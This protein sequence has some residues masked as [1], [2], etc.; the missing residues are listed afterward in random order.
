MKAIMVMY[1][2]LRRD[3][4]APYGC[5]WTH[6]PNFRR[7]AERAASFRN[8]YVGSMPCMPAR[9]ELHTGRYNL[10]HR[11]W[12]PLEPF[13]DSMPELLKNAG[14]Y[15]HLISDHYHYWEDGGGTF[16]NRY[17]SWEAVRGQE[18][19]NWKADLS[20][21]P[22]PTAQG[23]EQ[24]ADKRVYQK[25]IH[26]AVNRARMDSEEKMPQTKTFA[27]ALE[28]LETNHGADNWFLQ[29]ETFDPH[30]PFFTQPERR[31]LYPDSYVGD[32]AD[33]PPYRP[34]SEE[35]E[36]V[37]HIRNDYAAL[38]TMCD[39]YLGRIL[40]AMDTYDLWRDTM[41]IVNTDH[42]F[43][44]SEHGWWGKKGMPLYNEIAHV[45]LF[46]YDPRV[47]AAAGKTCDHL[48]QTVDLPA[49]LL[50]FFGQPLP[51]DMQGRPIGPALTGGGTV[52]D[53]ALYGF[54]GG[55]LNI[56]DGKH[57]YMRAPRDPGCPLYEY[58]LMPTHIHHRFRVEELQDI[59]LAEPFSFTKGCRLMQIAGRAWGDDID[60]G[61]LLFDAG[62]DEGQQAPL[63]DAAVTRQM[64]ALMERAMGENDAPAEQLARMGFLPR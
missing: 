4:L 2:S 10:L 53:Y 11:S 30:E 61:D 6:T 16:H 36:L 12:G 22:T 9:R 7:L 54:F 34:V 44:L 33:W 41:L 15:T 31:A 45:P 56:T 43:L 5:D 47:P 27:A 60:S 40:D 50:E 48:V 64:A 25:R 55:M 52:R 21:K 51:K 24:T 29:V 32:P 20:A 14:I 42:G 17:S 58:T 3:L 18:G 28:F 39:D 23:T 59:R 26:D 62:T 35:G 57:V 38:L 13:D 8:C 63:E 19:D 1:D 49:T 46:V 37:G